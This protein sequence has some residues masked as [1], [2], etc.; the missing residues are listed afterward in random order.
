M[1]NAAKMFRTLILTDGSSIRQ[2]LKMT[3]LNRSKDYTYLFVLGKQSI[4]QYSSVYLSPEKL[5]KQDPW[6]Y[7]KA[8]YAA[9]G[10]KVADDCKIIEDHIS[11]ELQFMGL[12]CN[13]ISEKL[14]IGDFD[15][16]DKL[17]KVQYEFYQ[18]HIKKWAFKYCNN[19]ISK[20]EELH[21]R[22]YTSFAYLLKGFITEDITLL[23]ELLNQ[24]T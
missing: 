10:F 5:L 22:F 4:S 15:S 13:Q 7:V 24:D 18:N 11:I 14:N 1:N 3:T 6:S 2:Y 17:L 23:E 8:Y 16:S 21:S 12:L 20:D 9:N 19:I